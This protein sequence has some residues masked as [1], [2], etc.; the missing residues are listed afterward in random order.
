[1]GNTE[2]K[3]VEQ[4]QVAPRHMV[5]VKE[6]KTNFFDPVV[7]GQMRG[8][9]ETFAASGAFPSTDNTAKIIVKL[10]AGR[11]MGMTPIESVKSFYFVNGQI[12][13]FGAATTR[14]LRE[15][16]WIIEFKDETDKCT[17]T[18]KRG[19][20]KYSDT[21]TFEEAEK[22]GWTKTQHGLKPGWL[23]GINRKLKLR[24]GAASLLIKTYV[25]E[26]L[27]S[28]V[29]I[30]EV[31][32]DAMPVADAYK[33]QIVGGSEPATEQAIESIKNMGGVLPDDVLSGE[34]KLTKQESADMI[35][36]LMEKKRVKK[37]SHEEHVDLAAKQGL[38]PIEEAAQPQI[39]EHRKAVDPQS[40]ELPLRDKD[41]EVRE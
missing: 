36:K 40:V 18:I 33:P 41:K 11:E 6:I 24:Y 21:L 19:K 2:E 38:T 34:R 25:P 1:M 26:V 37:N 27:G 3:T 12:T 16:G 17:A 7:W 31:A 30:S 39:E 14:R 35:K 20:E 22:S 29:D 15:H 9:A 23:P 5:S 8:M 10:Q 13:I 4:G 32:M 28:A